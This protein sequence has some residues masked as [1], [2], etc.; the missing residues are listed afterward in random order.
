MPAC[1][2]PVAKHR[3]E[4]PDWGKSFFELLYS[5]LATWDKST[6]VSTFRDEFSHSPEKAFARF[7]LGNKKQQ[8][9][10]D[11]PFCPLLDLN[12]SRIHST[13]SAFFFF[14][15]AMKSYLTVTSQCVALGSLA[16]S[17]GEDLN[18][19]YRAHQEWMAGQCCSPSRHFSAV[20]SVDREAETGLAGAS[21]PTDLV[22]WVFFLFWGFF[23]GLK[24]KTF[25]LLCVWD[26]CVIAI[27]ETR[28]TF[29]N[30]FPDIALMEK[31][32]HK[33]RES[34]GKLKYALL[35]LK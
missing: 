35:M 34:A 10:N 24:L 22:F 15:P 31:P 4:H 26:C 29:K 23:F 2:P 6:K 27:S 12:K 19:V 32:P 1:L 28:H 8:Q 33:D 9:K 18:W 17:E 7:L 11:L 14:F 30:R 13:F 25:S 20:G 16:L 5:C 21:F 3:W